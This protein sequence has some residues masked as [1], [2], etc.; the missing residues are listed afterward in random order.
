MAETP[1]ATPSPAPTCAPLKKGSL[2]KV[3]RTAYAGSLE[4]GASDPVAPDYLF[5]GPAEIL[6]VKGDYA[7]LRF[8]RP[9]PDIWLRLDQLLAC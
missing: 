9:V 1:T 2:V 6:A 3:N 5:E 8:R 4:A 7:Q